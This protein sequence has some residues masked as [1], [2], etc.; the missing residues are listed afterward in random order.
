M[1]PAQTQLAARIRTLNVSDGELLGHSNQGE[2]RRFVVDG[3]VL[4]IKSPKGRGLA[5]TFRQ[6]TLAHEYLAYQRLAGLTGFP[7]CH[8][9]VDRRWLLLDFV[10]GQPFRD[11]RLPDHEHFFDQLLATI[12][13]MHERGVAHGDLK[14]KDNLLVAEDG[15]PLILDLGAATLLK[16]GWHPLNRRLFDFIRQTDLNAWVKLKYGGYQGVSE[17]DAALLKRSG[18]ERLLARMR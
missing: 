4:A 5:W 7:S 14:R 18:L 8:G 3:Q 16:T 6:A 9:L 13:A 11:A 12:R 1:T 2:V 17:K 15:E 10:P